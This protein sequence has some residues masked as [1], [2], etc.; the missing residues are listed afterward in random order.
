MAQQI[1]QRGARTPVR[2]KR[3]YLPEAVTAS[4]A[5][6][7]ILSQR[8]AGEHWLFQC[9]EA[10][11][12]AV[13]RCYEQLRSGGVTQNEVPDGRYRF[14]ARTARELKE[15]A[16]EVPPVIRPKNVEQPQEQQD[17]GSELGHGDGSVSWVL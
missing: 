10:V 7:E 5:V 15:S 9:Q 8:F 14:Q 11:K 3:Q 17:E 4:E 2:P 13:Q 6:G 12:E 1:G 16:N